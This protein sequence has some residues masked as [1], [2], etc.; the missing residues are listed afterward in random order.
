LKGEGCVFEDHFPL[1]LCT[2]EKNDSNLVTK[3]GSPPFSNSNELN[4]LY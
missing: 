4:Y 3:K 1:N 2:K